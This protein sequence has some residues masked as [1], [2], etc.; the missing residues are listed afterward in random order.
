[1]PELHHASIVFWNLFCAAAAFV[2][3]HLL[4][5]GTSLR[6]RLVAGL[7]EKRYLGLFSL[8][9]ATGLVWL[10]VAYQQARNDPHNP[11]LFNLGPAIVH[12][13]APLMFVALTLMVMGLLSP[14]PTASGQDHRLGE[15]FE[16]AGIQRI[17]R[18]PFLWGVGLWSVIHLLCNGDAASLTL[19]GSFA[20]LS[21]AGTVSID[22]KL[23]IRHGSKYMRYR[24]L[25]SN[26]PFAAIVAGRNRLMWSELGWKRVAV[27]LVT[28][29]AV[30][31]LHPY[32]F[33]AS[34][35]PGGVVLVSR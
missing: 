27:T 35:L 31:V 26:I 24:T 32:L 10:I 34:P 8:A 4:V 1:M 23:G 9:S 7:G 33:G 17:T 2:A 29:V 5:A 14:N 28:F 3:L 18:H 22:R 12:A 6:G 13:A 11:T 16:P 25:T 21:F 20:L 19:F 15:S 30:L